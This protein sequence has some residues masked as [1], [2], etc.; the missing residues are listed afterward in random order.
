MMDVHPRGI[1]TQMPPMT[2]RSYR[3]LPPQGPIFGNAVQP[4]KLN[5]FSHKLFVNPYSTSYRLH[6]AAEKSELHYDQTK[7]I[8]VLDTGMKTL[9]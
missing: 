5:N 7:I 9:F 3:M 4:P 6:Q 8:E 1:K 2:D